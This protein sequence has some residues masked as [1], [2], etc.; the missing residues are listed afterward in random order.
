MSR[1]DLFAYFSYLCVD[2][3][4]FDKSALHV[5][6]LQDKKQKNDV[7]FKTALNYFI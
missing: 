4:T 6:D 3:S 5:A 7:D 1:R 2:A